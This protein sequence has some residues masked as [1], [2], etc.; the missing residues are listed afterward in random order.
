MGTKYRV[1]EFPLLTKYFVSNKFSV[2]FGPK[3]NILFQNGSIEEV[4]VSGTLG[5]K[6]DFNESFSMDARYNYYLNYNTRFNTNLPTV[7]P[8]LKL[9]DKFKF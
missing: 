8:I 2:L 6:Y 1:K 7:A 3:I 5:V 4:T 9:G